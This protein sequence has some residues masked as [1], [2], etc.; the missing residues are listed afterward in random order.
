MGSVERQVR[1]S[2]IPQDWSRP[3]KPGGIPIIP[4][5][6]TTTTVPKKVPCAFKLLNSIIIGIKII[7]RTKR[8][9][10]LLYIFFK[11]IFNHGSCLSEGIDTDL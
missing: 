6:I 9:Q 7:E 10:T 3:A 5:R 2:A 8:M 1:V 11:Y 4:F